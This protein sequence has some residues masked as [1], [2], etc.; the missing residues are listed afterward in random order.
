MEIDI[1]KDRPNT[2]SSYYVS[3]E[4]PSYV[5]YNLAMSNNTT[6]TL[7]NHQCNIS[8]PVKKEK[9]LHDFV[10]K[11]CEN[12]KEADVYADDDLQSFSKKILL[13]ILHL[14]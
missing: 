7:Q 3:K 13:L 11:A 9:R 8:N 6:A 14:V 5:K 4:S 2:A 12:S 1:S 10:C